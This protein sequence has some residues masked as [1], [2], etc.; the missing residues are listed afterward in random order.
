MS[1]GE[2]TLADQRCRK[3]YTLPVHHRRAVTHK[4]HH[5]DRSSGHGH[6]PDGHPPAVSHATPLADATLCYATPPDDV[7]IT[8]HVAK[9]GS[10]LLV[11]DMAVTY[12]A[13]CWFLGYRY[14]GKA[15]ATLAR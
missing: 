10:L 5:T 6:R 9:Q 1:N 11:S 13:T 15:L 7:I 3:D 12:D 2:F 14:C 8:P 4:W